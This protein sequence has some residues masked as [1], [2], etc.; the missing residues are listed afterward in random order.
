MKRFIVIILVTIFSVSSVHAL[1]KDFH[2][3][4]KEANKILREART[5]SQQKKYSQAIQMLGS[6]NRELA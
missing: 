6:L 2:V 3:A 4:N 5:L 1:D